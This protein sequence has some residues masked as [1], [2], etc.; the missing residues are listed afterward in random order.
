MSLPVFS[1]Y[2]RLTTL[3]N[4]TMAVG[5]KKNSGQALMT[6]VFSLIV[7]LIFLFLGKYL[8]NESLVKVVPNIKKI[9]SVWELFLLILLLRLLFSI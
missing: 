8:W 5:T 6:M 3:I 7:F 4:D 9:E 1:L 2:E